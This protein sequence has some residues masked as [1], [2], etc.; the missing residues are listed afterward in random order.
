LL[1]LGGGDFGVVVVGALVVCGVGA[2]AAAPALRRLRT[3]YAPL[4]K[5]FR[6]IA[7]NGNLSSAAL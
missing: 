4:I 1:Q 6:G 5:E 3:A 7:T 2:A